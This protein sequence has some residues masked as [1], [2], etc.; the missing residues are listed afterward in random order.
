[1]QSLRKFF[2]SIL[3]LHCMWCLLM[4]LHK[5][6]LIYYM[7]VTFCLV[8]CRHEG[9]LLNFLHS[10]YV[11]MKMKFAGLSSSNSSS[12]IL[13]KERK[14]WYSNV[15]LVRM[16]GDISFWLIFFLNHLLNTKYGNVISLFRY[17][18][19]YVCWE[20]YWHCVR[21]LFALSVLL[22]VCMLDKIP[23]YIFGLLL[24]LILLQQNQQYSQ[25][26][27]QKYL[28]FGLNVNQFCD[29]V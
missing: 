2:W 7:S 24:Y 26:E 9:G 29:V 20:F 13:K 22:V 18:N 16:F 10:R 23:F 28:K 27:E 8:V 25:L 1:M 5:R 19:N 3:H 6:R 12:R 21:S 15:K 17:C 14:F 11:T 4:D